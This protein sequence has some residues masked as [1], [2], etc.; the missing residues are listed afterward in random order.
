MQT[1]SR[2]AKLQC[3][4]FVPDGVVGVDGR[5]PCVVYLHCNSGSRRDAEEALC[6]LIPLGVSVFTLDFEG[7]G[8]SDGK[9]VTLGA[10]EVDDLETAV[11][12]LRATNKV[13]TLGL[14]GRSMGAVT[15]LLYGQRNPC[16]AGMVLDSPFS[17]LTDLMLEIVADQKLP[18]PKPLMKVSPIDHVPCSFIPALFGHA[19]SDSFVRINHSELLHAAYAGDKNFIKFEGDHNSRRSDFFYN[20]V[21]CFFHNTLQLDRMLVGGNP[22]DKEL[23]RLFSRGEQRSSSPNPAAVSAAR[24]QGHHVRR[25]SSSNSL[26]DIQSP[27]STRTSAGNMNGLHQQQQH[28]RPPRPPEVPVSP[29]VPQ[30]PPI[31][32]A[33]PFKASQQQQ[34]QQQQKQQQHQLLQQQQ[35]QQQLQEQQQ[36]QQQQQQ[37]QQRKQEP[38]VASITCTPR[39]TVVTV[40]GMPSKQLLDGGPRPPSASALAPRRASVPPTAYSGQSG[41]SDSRTAANATS[42]SSP[43][44]AAAAAAG[45]VGGAARAGTAPG[46]A[47]GVGPSGGAVKDATDLLWEAPGSTAATTPNKPPARWQAGTAEPK[48]CSLKQQLASSGF[49]RTSAVGEP[50]AEQA[51][52]PLVS[53]SSSDEDVAAATAAALSEQENEAKQAVEA[54]AAAEEEE[55]LRVAMARSLQ[56]K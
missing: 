53:A 51:G 16:I 44:A 33:S 19:K 8:L 34:H 31:P 5:L 41:V 38:A 15:A 56:I 39:S 36:Q 52:G 28:P 48:G 43:A 24:I 6:V 9:Y 12:H 32:P 14:W 22:L 3:S 7:S 20:S 29:T 10:R 4:H 25:S 50:A 26:A 13:S 47:A 35:Q 30:K 18:I 21:A 46:A 17:R 40:P 1:N 11:E 2:G 42:S 45:G 23:R 55:M 54:A 49:N 27:T 37:P